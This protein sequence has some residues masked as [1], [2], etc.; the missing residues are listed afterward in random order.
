M[1]HD[2]ISSKVVLLL[3]Y[4]MNLRDVFC[5]GVGEGAVP[6]IEPSGE[7]NRIVADILAHHLSRWRPYPCVPSYPPLVPLIPLTVAIPVSTS[8]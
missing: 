4:A 7:G 6:R 3:F 1:Q 2:E 8:S 5:G